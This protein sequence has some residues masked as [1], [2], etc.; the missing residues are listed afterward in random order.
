M[1][2]VIEGIDRCGK[3]T[4][5]RKLVDYFCNHMRVAAWEFPDR[6]TEIGKRIDAYLRKVEPL[7]DAQLLFAENRREKQAELEMLLGIPTLVICARYYLSGLAYADRAGSI[8]QES[9]TQGQRR[10]DITILIDMPANV[11][12]RRPGFG[13][14]LYEKEEVQERVRQ[15]YLTLCDSTLCGDGSRHGLTGDLL[16]VDGCADI[17]E[18]AARCINYI[19]KSLTSLSL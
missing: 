12:A 14:E 9:I 7:H 19:A 5:Q 8:T 1:F 11:A 18:I 16:I 3:S 15:S 13:A 10:P 2:V 17:D 6:T 4:L